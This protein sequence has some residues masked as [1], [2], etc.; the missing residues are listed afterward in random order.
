VSGQGGCCPPVAIRHGTGTADSPAAAEGGQAEGVVWIAGG[1]SHVGTDTPLL[2][3][4]GEGPVRAVRL[5]PYGIEAAAV[6]N[7][8]FARFVAATGYVTEAERIGWSFVFRGFLPPALAARLPPSV[9][10]PWWA[11]VEG[12]CWSAPEGP[13][14]SIAGREDHPV[15]HVSWADAT[16]F[17]RWA[18]GRLPTEAEWEHAA[19]GGGPG[20]YP[21]GAQEPDDTGFFPCNIWQGPFPDRNLL[22]DGHAG[23]APVRS[24]APNGLGLFNTVGNVWEWC[25][26]AFR[27]RS[28]GRQ[29][30]A[31][32]AVAQAQAH[33]VI[34]GGSY[35][36]H[37]SYCHRYRIA[38]RLGMPPDSATGHMGFRIAFDTVPA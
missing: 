7:A 20:P 15:V 37:A 21:W 5:A 11:G 18:G 6:S 26:D 30:R 23:T 16:A 35:L 8:R 12:A 17:A 31:R 38:A 14:S 22:H 28:A 27:V 19:R 13:G 29:A 24:F 3:A 4:D 25:A 36:C 10:A 9:D 2:R 1:R 34:K 33:R 32:N